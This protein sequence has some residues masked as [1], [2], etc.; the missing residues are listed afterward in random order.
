MRQARLRHI[1]Y[2]VDVFLDGDGADYQNSAT[3]FK[4]ELVG[5]N[6]SLRETQS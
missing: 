2:V 1:P 5:A 3:L 6:F 4:L